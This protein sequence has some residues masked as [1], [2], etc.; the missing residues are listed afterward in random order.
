MREKLLNGLAV[1]VSGI[2]D[3]VEAADSGKR[4]L[5]KASRDLA[6]KFCRETNAW[7]Q[8]SPSHEALSEKI[9]D[10]DELMPRITESS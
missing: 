8:T 1:R 10:I 9:D 7:L 4:P 6:L 2:L 3:L 5:R